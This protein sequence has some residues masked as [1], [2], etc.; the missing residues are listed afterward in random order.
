MTGTATAAR[1]TMVVAS[2]TQSADVVRAIRMR[3]HTAFH[4]DLCDAADALSAMRHVD[5]VV[6]V[7][8][9][10]PSG[11]GLRAVKALRTVRRG[12]GLVHASSDR[13]VRTRLRAYVGGADLHFDTAAD[14]AEIAAA[15]EALGWRVSRNRRPQWT[16]AAVLTLS[17]A[18]LCLD[19]PQ[20]G[21]N[22]TP[23]EADVLA[24]LAAAPEHRLDLAQLAAALA[25]D[26]VACTHE[27]LVTRV[28]RLRVK[29][30]RTGIARQSLRARRT[31]GYE[32]AV[33]LRV[34]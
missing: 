14:V 30:E 25:R 32:L 22:V 6:V 18:R 26:G 23:A 8:Q 1:L 5:V 7:E 24:A 33:P 3:G 13:R 34:V 29:L 15:S 28:A 17:R 12:I 27:A 21:V 31:L 2:D 11:A 16:G 4:V 9:G 20:G 19:G 10:A